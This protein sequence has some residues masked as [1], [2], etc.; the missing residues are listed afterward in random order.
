MSIQNKK[1]PANDGLTKEFFVTFWG[2]IKYVF[3]NS[4]RTAKPKKI[5]H[6]AKTGYH[7]AN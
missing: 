5:K 2:D 4:C 6:F 1:L 3:L 7:K